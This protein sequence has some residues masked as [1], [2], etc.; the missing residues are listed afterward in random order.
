LL[1]EFS[2]LALAAAC[3]ETNGGALGSDTGR[4]GGDARE[5]EITSCLGLDQEACLGTQGCMAVT[6][7]AGDDACAASLGEPRGPQTFVACKDITDCSTAEVWAR[8]VEDPDDLRFFSEWCE[9]P[10]WELLDP[11]YPGDGQ[12]PGDNCWA[13]P[14]HYCS[15]GASLPET[16]ACAP[17]LS[18]CCRYSNTCVPCGWVFCSYCEVPGTGVEVE[19]YDGMEPNGTDV[20]PECADAPLSVP[21]D[22]ACPV[23]D[24]DAPI[25]PQGS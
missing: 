9:P 10:G 4:T 24:W 19:C 23:I 15:E 7:W 11:R 22:P 14:E 25:C 8:A 6:A 21:G 16:K 1:L 5:A 2:L 12:Q 3:A 18:V 13:P 20:A 17:D